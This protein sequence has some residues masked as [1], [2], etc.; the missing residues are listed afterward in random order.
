MRAT[1]ALAA[2]A[3]AV[4][5]AAPELAPYA[6]L[7]RDGR[8]AQRVLDVARGALRGDTAQA[9]TIE[10]PGSPRAAQPI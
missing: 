4:V 5:G 10:W 2:M 9:A 8:A 7:A 3:F 1:L 6:A